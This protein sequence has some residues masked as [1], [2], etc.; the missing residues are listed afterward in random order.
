MPG[1][2]FNRST[3]SLGVG[4]RRPLPNSVPAGGWNNLAEDHPL[5]IAAK[6]QQAGIRQR[7]LQAG[8]PLV[9][10]GQG[11][12][13]LRPPGGSFY[14][15]EYRAMHPTGGIDSSPGH[16]GMFGD[17]AR[18]AQAYLQQTTPS[19][20]QQSSFHQDWAHN[21]DR[22]AE[23]KA[24]QEPQWLPERL[25]AET[26]V[27]TQG[28]RYA[29]AGGVLAGRGQPMGQGL[30]AGVA[31]PRPPALGMV[32]PSAP[33]LE[34]LPTGEP[35]GSGLNL[36]SF[37]TDHLGS[38]TAGD[39]AAAG[40]IELA[41][42]AALHAASAP[43]PHPAVAGIANLL[44]GR[45]EPG[46][47]GD[48]YRLLGNPD[49]PGANTPQLGPGVTPE[50]IAALPMTRRHYSSATPWGARLNMASRMMPSAPG[51]APGSP[52][53][54]GDPL[55]DA[56]EQIARNAANPQLAAM[57]RAKGLEVSAEA[58]RQAAMDSAQI[59]H[60]G[61][62]TNLATVEAAGMPTMNAANVGAANA[63]THRAE[64]E[65]KALNDANEFGRP[66]VV[67]EQ[68]VRDHVIDMNTYRGAMAKM[69]AAKY[70][71]ATP[72]PPAVTPPAPP[73][74]SPPAAAPPAAAPIDPMTRL[75]GSGH[76]PGLFPSWYDAMGATKEQRP[77][78]IESAYD[79]LVQHGADLSDPRTPLGQ[80]I[81][82]QLMREYGPSS[83]E[84]AG[85]NDWGWI[86]STT[87]EEQLRARFFR[88][89]APPA[90]RPGVEPG[91]L[92]KLF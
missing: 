2:E 64:A 59:G 16:P 6:Q 42:M 71:V 50:A 47:P 14:S 27:A 56:Y 46:S 20:S 53:G 4:T 79:A 29:P 68:L 15:G 63:Q 57:Y 32:Q 78:D 80:A 7:A 87:P 17:S 38:L 66:G 88:G 34:P 74:A 72:A 1:F 22:M 85:R 77:G 51:V 25:Q 12:A 54:S 55:I 61:A 9:A 65:T 84:S 30:L 23:F 43:K 33:T 44:T 35:S 67:L 82:D 31:V 90:K 86:Y 18:G 69:A 92:W 40:G 11:N 13:M 39:G 73:S 81:R 45:P 70:G 76:Q 37:L 10:P 83:A 24:T 60:L 8:G 26:S 28:R 48:P 75:L 5:A 52:G 58:K 91:V 49:Q 62:Q 89:E 19:L 36:H 21:P 41:A 3:N